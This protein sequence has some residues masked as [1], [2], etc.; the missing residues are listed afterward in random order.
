MKD[1]KI[2]IDENSGGRK[3][4]DILRRDAKLS[5]NLLT[6]LKKSGGILLNGKAAISSYI[7]NIGDVVE[8]HFADEE[9]SNI[10]AT[11]IPIE[12][13]YEDEHILAVNKP[14]DMP[15]H[16]SIGNYENTLGNACMYYYRDVN[17][18][19]RPVNRLDRDTTGIVI[20]AKDAITSYLLAEQMK[21]GIF[22]KTYYA[23]TS[24]I[25][26][27]SR[28]IIDAPICRA[29]ESIVK[30]EVSVN[31]QRAVTE[32]E[33][34]N[35]ENNIALLKIKLHTGRTHQIRVHMAH[36]GTPLLYDYMYGTEVA[37]KTLFLHCG[38]IEFVHPFTEK[39]M[40]LFCN[41]KFPF[42]N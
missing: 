11:N 32:Y 26:N 25:P 5:A 12:I 42:F 31:G 13:I 8:I 2:I 37:G 30:R 24:G 16:P 38:E 17:F 10:P 3:L 14:K 41:Y 28:G 7:V 20:I 15:T 36:I 29:S 6:K 4:R 35:S 1:L 9:K 33:T 27:P 23:I 39:K 18:V 40:K 34:V 19:F 21:A 22:K